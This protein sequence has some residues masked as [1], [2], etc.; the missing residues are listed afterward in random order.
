MKHFMLGINVEKCCV[1]LRAVTDLLYSWQSG[2]V[3]CKSSFP[4]FFYTWVVTVAVYEQECEKRERYGM[5]V[6]S[7][8]LS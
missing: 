6:F 2:F 1:H 8:S 7:L 4:I 5:E 3:I